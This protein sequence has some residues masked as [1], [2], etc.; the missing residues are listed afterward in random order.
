[1]LRPLRIKIDKA[2]SAR[3]L[4]ARRA[5]LSARLSF[6]SLCRRFTGGA[7]RDGS[8]R[9]TD[10]LSRPAPRMARTNQDAYLEVVT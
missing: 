4:F 8:G 10:A 6:L 2:H 5:H 9:L 3:I 7:V 1:M